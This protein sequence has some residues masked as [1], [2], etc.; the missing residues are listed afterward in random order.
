MLPLL[1]ACASVDIVLDPTVTLDPD[2]STT[3]TVT[4]DTPTEGDGLVRYGED[5]SYGVEVV[6]Q[7]S[8]DGLAH[9]AVISGLPPGDSFHLRVES[10]TIEGFLSSDDV[11]VTTPLPPQDLPELYPEDTDTTHLGASYI[12][13]SLVL[14]PSAGVIFDPSATWCGGEARRRARPSSSP[15]CRPT[16]PRSWCSP[17]QRT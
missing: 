14:E 13:T 1:L 10:A 12:L 2:M 4:W 9:Q 8:A 16:G 7:D 11:S 6:A 17:P 3:I 5:D 15:A